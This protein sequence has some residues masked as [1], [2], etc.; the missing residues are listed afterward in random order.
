MT[1]RAFLGGAVSMAVLGAGFHLPDPEPRVA[2]VRGLSPTARWHEAQRAIS[3]GIEKCIGLKETPAWLTALAARRP[4]S[5][6]I[7]TR[8]PLAHTKESVITGMLRILLEQGVQQSEI[9][10][11]DQRASDVLRLN[12][13]LQ[14][15]S[16]SIPVRWVEAVNA[17]GDAAVGYGEKYTYTPEWLKDDVQASGYAGLLDPPPPALI[18]M[19]A[20]THH[21]HLGICGALASL[22]L[23]SV[24][25][26]KRFLHKADDLKRAV[27]EIWKGEPLRGHALTVM[28]ATHIVFNGGPVGLPAWTSP[29]GSLIIGTDPVAVDAVALRLLN[30]RRLA[31]KLPSCL[32]I[33]QAFLKSAEEMGLGSANPKVVEVTLPAF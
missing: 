24:S 10:V 32:E 23:G 16:G 30:G 18:N 33:G 25:R 14:T 1:R 3:L 15:D 21:P 6:K 9:G 17:R 12:L 22:A 2:L 31:A 8:S 4:V 7:D 28:D 29:D 19:P 27:C 13:R 26:T 11:W 5:L 20:A